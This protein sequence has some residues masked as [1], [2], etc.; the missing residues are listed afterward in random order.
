MTPGDKKEHLQH[1][2]DRLHTII[3][4]MGEGVVVT[5]DKG[6]VTFMNKKALTDLGSNALNATVDGLMDIW[7]VRPL[8]STVALKAHELPISL[9]LKNK[10]RSELECRMDTERGK[11]RAIRLISQPIVD[12]QNKL[13]GVITTCRDITRKRGSEQKLLES[14]Q[15]YLSL[16]DRINEGLM[17]M[18]LNG[19]IEFANDRFCK[20]LGKDLHDVEGA[21]YFDLMDV[22]HKVEQEQLKA[23]IAD[24]K[25]WSG[26]MLLHL[27]HT[28]TSIRAMDVSISPLKDTHE[29]LVG[30]MCIHTDVTEREAMV[31]DLKASEARY[32]N[33]MER[34][35]EGILIVDGDSRIQY[36]NKF[37]CESLGYTEKELVGNIS[38]EV[39]QNMNF[40][41]SEFLKKEAQRKKGISEV[42]EINL[43]TKEG[44]SRWYKV[45][46]SPVY[47]TEERIIG[48]MGV[49][50]DITEQKKVIE[51]N[52]RLLTVIGS[53]TDLLMVT[54]YYGRPLYMNQAVR[55]MLGI[56]KS[57]DPQELCMS[58]FYTPESKMKFE[59]EI[60]PHLLKHNTWQGELH[61]INKKGI[62][63]PV[64]QVL[65]CKKNAEGRVEYFASIIRDITDVKQAQREIA[66][67][68]RMPDENPAPVLRVSGNGVV[69]YANAASEI[70]LKS[71]KTKVGKKMPDVWQRTVNKVLSSGHF[72]EFEADFGR[73]VFDLKIVPIAEYDYVNI[74]ASDITHRKKAEKQL[75]AS[76]KKYRAIVEDQT[77]LIS[78]FLADGT[79]TFANKAY[80]RYYGHD[81]QKVLGKNLFNIIPKE[82]VE[83]LKQGLSTLTP[84]DP[85]VTYNVFFDDPEHPRWQ[86]WTDRAIYDDNGFFIEY[87]SVGQDITALKQIE[88]ELRKQEVYLRQIIDSLPNIVYVKGSDGRYLMVNRS[89]SD[90][91][92]KDIKD[93]VGKTDQQLFG[94]G[95]YS[96]DYRAS[97]K[98]VLKN[99][100]T[101]VN[102][103]D[104]HVNEQT[105]ETRWFHTVK[106]PLVTGRK[107]KREIL[108]VSTDI[109]ERMQI[110]QALK[111][112]LN[113]KELTSRISSNFINLSYADIDDGISQA[114]A[115]IGE[116]NDV[117]RAVIALVSDK[118]HVKQSYHWYKDPKDEEQ[119][120][121][122]PETAQAVPFDEGLKELEK[123]GYLYVP[124]VLKLKGADQ[125][126]DTSQQKGIRS[127]LV[128]S[129]E[130]KNEIMGFMTLSSRQPEKKWTNDTIAMLQ[131]IGQTFSGALE[132][133]STEALLNFTLEF[134]NIITT[135]SAN[136]IN[137]QSDQINNEIDTALRYVSQFLEV[138]HGAVFL[139]KGE[140]AQ[141]SLTNVWLQ[142]PD[143]IKDEYLKQVESVKHSWVYEQMQRFGVLSVPDVHTLPPQAKD[144]RALLK[145]TGTRAVV[146]VPIIYRGD[147]TGVLL[148][149]SFSQ[150]AF[151]PEEAVP[152]MKIL[153]Q[154]IA[155]ALDRLRTEEYLS[156]TREMY[157]TLA[158]N[159]P[160]AAVM[161]FDRDLRYRLVE[162]AELEEQ[163]FFKDGME[164]KTL[165]EVLPGSR[166]KELEPLYRKALGGEQVMFERSY[167]NKHY[168]IH[169][170]PVRNEQDE[171]SAGMVM[172][173][174][175]SDLKN[176]Q[177]KLEEQ[178]KE[179]MRSNEDL[180][181]F[182]YAASHDL[183]EPLRMVS[184]YVHLIQ[185]RLGKVS[186][187]VEEFMN[188][189]VDGVKR[190]QEVINDL[191][192]YSRVDRKGSPFQLVDLN[193]VLQL[194]QINLQNVIRTSGATIVM[195]KPLPKA[196][197]DQ[198]QFISLFQNLIENAIKFK[199]DKPPTIEISYE[200]H[201]D[202]WMF[203]VKD[204][205]IGIEK[206]FFERIFI[207]FQ[208]LNSRT[209]YEGTGIGLA[210]CKKIV[211]RH[212]GNIWLGSEPGEGTTF[213][214]EFPKNLK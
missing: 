168:L 128:I 210:I 121:K 56:K 161:L 134:E 158:R 47:D 147:F 92:G 36:A 146:G 79:I 102:S 164:G 98:D 93:L 82:S 54:N 99:N 140:E 187:E 125:V 85:V 148:F 131:I 96:K 2:N 135:I 39:L 15:M 74:I 182:A 112:Q 70:L 174:D 162:G 18:D 133:K 105:G 76:E 141:L 169:I 209:E 159:I 198:S 165:R 213:Y 4:A 171:V 103:E 78:R 199:S 138:D 22:D 87:Q 188:F 77:E 212:S 61:I 193:K 157:R 180:E 116:F 23:R 152:L 59:T 64:S 186:P 6:C 175:I 189:A 109:T 136:F 80:C 29:G 68:A 184:S 200:E 192:E 66:I 46:A 72:K 95:G 91:L 214:F 48:S 203:Q 17:L 177:R 25:G 90:L 19:K 9:T 44:E 155:N 31:K 35:N 21:D 172:S 34:M 137:I 170:L 183:Q 123:N 201:E 178:T 30:A 143:K 51:E 197:V 144:L 38:Y 84:T 16:I 145:A 167:N 163:G 179:L 20:M 110:E 28:D 5:D 8:D 86:L 190:M 3:N 117:D 88:Q 65:L 185:R 11:D 211:E 101:Y 27:K 73:K 42:Y 108:G 100:S 127:L 115:S 176:T 196:V 106:T 118:R 97:D 53:T 129:L 139:N 32:R 150:E 37:F 41:R 26:R 7:N 153:G 83:D 75:V 89:F 142:D 81:P 45:S 104:K 10:K 33:L 132:R 113:L 120:K 49:H 191:L 14:E 173:L 181:L 166:V 114:L 202:R 160:K 194:V 94:K 57:Q 154:I 206:K 67:L 60:V 63:V 151:W 122:K 111:F 126:K 207:I 43:L 149:G 119:L 130:S 69:V 58:D 124:D 1:E 55:K 24:G 204:N 205:G 40:K 62:T 71:W 195:E 50:T 208:R 156:E 12:H 52:E 107:Q 13:T